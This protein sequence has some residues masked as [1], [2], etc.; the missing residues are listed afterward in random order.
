MIGPDLDLQRAIV[1]R[2]KS[3]TDLQALISNPI[4]LFQD[5]PP[6]P[7]FP[8]LTIGQSQR[9]PDE[10]ECIPGSIVFTDLNF[11]TRAPGYEQVKLIGAV[12]VEALHDAT[13]TLSEH[14]CRQIKVDNEQYFVAPDNLTKHGLLTFRA[15]VEP[16]S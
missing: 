2:L 4:R 1:T 9:I 3:D 10:A 7:T 5:V 12:L 11:Y 13:L 8:Y 14:W 16:T 6:G 15:L